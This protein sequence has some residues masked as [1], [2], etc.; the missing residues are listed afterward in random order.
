MAYTELS[1]TPKDLHIKDLIFGG[2]ANAIAR[3]PIF[4]PGVSQGGKFT[5]CELCEKGFYMS[6]QD[7]RANEYRCTSCRPAPTCS[8]C[9]GELSKSRVKESVDM[10]SDCEFAFH[11]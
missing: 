1:Q 2:V 4:L 5:T 10:C 7:A 3:L 11:F 9:E 8:E 6:E